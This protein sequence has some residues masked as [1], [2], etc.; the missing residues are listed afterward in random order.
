M[1]EFARSL[2]SAI[3]IYYCVSRQ[4]REKEKETP[5]ACEVHDVQLFFQ[6]T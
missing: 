6:T 4:K 1:G 3:Y 2:L 5:T